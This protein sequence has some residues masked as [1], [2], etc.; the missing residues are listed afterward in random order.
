MTDTDFIIDHLSLLTSVLG[1]D[2]AMC[3]WFIGLASR[4]PADRI[5]PLQ[6]I[7]SE[8]VARRESEHLVRAFAL[9]A[10]ARIFRAVHASL[11]EHGYIP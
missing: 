7:V 11:V 5:V 6:Q 2:R 1:D 3:A 4:V 10:D 8:M 9:L